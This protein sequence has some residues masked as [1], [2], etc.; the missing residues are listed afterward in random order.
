MFLN[1]ESEIPSLTEITLLQFIFLDFQAPFKNFLGLPKKRLV[2]A[3]SSKE[4]IG[5]IGRK[6]DLWSTNSDVNGDFFVPADTECTNRITSLEKSTPD[7]QQQ[8]PQDNNKSYNSAT[9]E[10]GCTFE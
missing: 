10:E 4:G 9:K 5:A 6:R 1:T 2:S 7:P 8:L 3:S